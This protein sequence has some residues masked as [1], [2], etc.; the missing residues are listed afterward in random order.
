MPQRQQRQKTAGIYD[1]SANTLTLFGH[2]FNEMG[3][4]GLDYC[5]WTRGDEVAAQEVEAEQLEL[6]AAI[7]GAYG[8]GRR[9]VTEFCVASA[10]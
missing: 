3:V 10:P 8:G 2:T 6:H 9:G 1:F 7:G 4:T 5:P